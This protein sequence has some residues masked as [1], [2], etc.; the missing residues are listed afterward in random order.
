M[1][2]LGVW[3]GF[4]YYETPSEEA[5]DRAFAEALVVPDAN[6]LLDFYRYGSA[7]RTNLLAALQAA[8]DRLY[9]PHRVLEEFWRNRESAVADRAIMNP[10]VIGELSDI[11]DK[12][13][14]SFASWANRVA[15][16]EDQ[17]SSAQAELR[18]AF[19]CVKKIVEDFVGPEKRLRERDTQLDSILT[20]ITELLENRA[21]SPLPPEEHSAALKEAA[22]RTQLGEPPGY[23]DAK[24]R[25]DERVAGDYLVWK[26]SIDQAKSRGL[27]LLLVTSDAK[28][29][30]W[31]IVHGETRGPRVELQREL[32]MQCGQRLFMLR[33]S[34]LISLH[35]RALGKSDPDIVRQLVRAEQAQENRQLAWTPEQ[36]RLVLDELVEYYPAQCEAVLR[37]VRNGGFV[38]RTDVYEI[39][40]YEPGRTLRGFTRPVNRI[41]Q[42]VFD[43]EGAAEDPIEVFTSRYDPTYSWVQASGFDLEETFLAAATTAGDVARTDEDE[44]P[45]TDSRSSPHGVT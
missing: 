2:V 37:A 30:W 5:Y 31:H 10:P 32:W 39:G 4:E 6:V 20:S 18:S 11:H 21:G 38:T 25:D 42:A 40:G 45:G 3:T 15:L 14:Q 35:Q 9:V 44:S 8:D 7:T 17:R 36:V 16:A 28:E 27:D 24:K 29:D 12:A 22:R 43:P 13:T 33:P 41:A 23:R 34:R 19:E 1:G 26:Q